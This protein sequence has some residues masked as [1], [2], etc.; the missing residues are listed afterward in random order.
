MAPVP[1]DRP[2]SVR[3]RQLG[4][5]GRIAGRAHLEFRRPRPL[6]REPCA[7]RHHSAPPKA[8]IAR[9]H[10]RHER[11]TA[12]AVDPADQ[13]AWRSRQN[14][15]ASSSIA[16]A[17]WCALID[18]RSCWGSPCTVAAPAKVARTAEWGEG[19]KRKRPP[20][21]R[22]WAPLSDGGVVPGIRRRVKLRRDWRN[23]TG[24][25]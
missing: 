24:D 3:R 17:I 13:R 18:C 2:S 22:L 20:A 25:P 12:L 9:V 21:F 16:V 15:A 11:A 7:G 4:H 23:S 10:S 5:L 6:L 19:W 1:T 8:S 14:A